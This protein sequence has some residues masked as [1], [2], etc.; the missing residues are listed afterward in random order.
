MAPEYG[1]P[2]YLDMTHNLLLFIKYRMGILVRFAIDTKDI[3]HFQVL[4]VPVYS[5]FYAGLFHGSALLYAVKIIKRACDV[6]NPLLNEVEV[7]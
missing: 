5:R 2:A 6:G 3:G 7:D 4:P 1:S